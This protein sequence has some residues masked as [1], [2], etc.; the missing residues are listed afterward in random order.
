MEFRL[1]NIHIWFWG[2]FSFKSKKISLNKVNQS[3][4]DNKLNMAL[5]QPS[6]WDCISTK[7]V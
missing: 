4:I 2:E 5:I 1:K 6:V 7:V 3:K